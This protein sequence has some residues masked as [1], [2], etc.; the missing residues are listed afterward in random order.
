MEYTLP[1]SLPTIPDTAYHVPS[2]LLCVTS[3]G[4]LFHAKQ[5]TFAET[6]DG[7]IEEGLKNPVSVSGKPGF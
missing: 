5:A 2:G 7:V 4:N 6:D 3:Q 1:T